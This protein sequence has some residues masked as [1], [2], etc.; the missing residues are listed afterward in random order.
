MTNNKFKVLIVGAGI[1][2]LCIAIGLRKQGHHVVLLESA[3]Q[4]SP[5][6]AGIHVP[7]NATLVLEHWNLLD[8]FKHVAIAPAGFIF[9]RYKN[10]S[11][12]AQPSRPAP[13]DDAPTTPYWSMKRS[14]YQQGLYE[15]TLEV[16]VEI[17]LGK[18]VATMDQDNAS[19]TT[20]DGETWT[21]NLVIVA[22]GIK[23]RLRQQIIDEQDVS[24]ILQPLSTYRAMVTREDLMADPQASAL[25]AN[26]GT[27][28]WLGPSRHVIIYPAENGKIYAVNGTHP[29]HNDSA[30][31]WNKPA[32]V[33]EIQAKFNDFDPALQGLLAKVRDC[34]SWALAEVPRLPRW[35]SKSGK[36]VLIGDAAHGML[37]FLAQGA[38]MATEDAAALAEALSRAKSVENI[39]KAMRVYERSRKWRC[40]KVQANAR[41]N[42]EFIHMP[43]GEEQEHR[44]R[45]MAGL[46]RPD[47][48][49]VDTGP[50]LDPKFAS[51]LYGHN[52]FEHTRKLLDEAGL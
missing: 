36:V 34:K 49:E 5:V 38:A 42:G 6:G 41:R 18:R 47:D 43:D 3:H 16:G 4:L 2:G 30:G 27:N 13:S 35:T 20:T 25:F 29:A 31:E 39:P 44:D 11:I 24:A 45:K 26:G 21:G 9:R 51:W 46:Q 15:A 7:P 19:V 52:A 33:A 32:N 14:D 50:L 22:D 10:S 23:S 17:F 48:Q 37:Q 8:R 12:L 28:V 40:E 1:A